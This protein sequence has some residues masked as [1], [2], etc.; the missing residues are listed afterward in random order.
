MK[1]KIREETPA[2][3]EEYGRVPMSFTVAS[4]LVPTALGPNGLGGIQ[5]VE[6]ALDTPYKKDYDD[7]GGPERWRRWDLSNW[8]IFSAF[9]DGE[10]AGGAVVAYRT[11][12]VNFLKGRDDLAA[13]W[14][15]RVAPL[16][17]GQG[18]GRALFQHV[19]HWARARDDAL[20]EIE[21]QNNNVAAC[22]FYAAQGCTLGTID[23]FAYDDLP[24]ETRLIWYKELS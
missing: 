11:E 12:E 8:G 17:Q 1:I 18:I 24:D 20:L 6:E 16:Y 9:V 3:L 19:E 2:D 5:L 21:T 10:R 22:R 13:L 15:L 7:D 14:D 23:R 4:Q